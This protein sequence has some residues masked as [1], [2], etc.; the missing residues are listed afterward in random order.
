MKRVSGQ[1]VFSVSRG[2]EPS[3]IWAI[4]LL[5]VVVLVVKHLGW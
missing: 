4:F 5:V 3:I 2:R 1:R